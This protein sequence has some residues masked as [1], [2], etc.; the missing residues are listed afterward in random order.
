MNRK[1]VANPEMAQGA[2][3]WVRPRSYK[4]KNIRLANKCNGHDTISP[5]NEMV[6]LTAVGGQIAV[7]YLRN[8]KYTYMHMR[9]ERIQKESRKDP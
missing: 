7:M 5:Q 3:K 2:Q 6:F 8:T 9:P 1:Y 4:I